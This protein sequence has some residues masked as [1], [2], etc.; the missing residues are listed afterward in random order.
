M[1][2]VRSIAFTGFCALVFALAVM[3]A[4]S[5]DWVSLRLGIW[6]V[7]TALGVYGVVLGVGRWLDAQAEEQRRNPNTPRR[8]SKLRL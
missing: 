1:Q 8:T 7:T 2:D 5:A 4:M 6:L 3:L